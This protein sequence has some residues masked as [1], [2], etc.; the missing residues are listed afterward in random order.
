MQ[1]FEKYRPASLNAV[2]GQDKAVAKVQQ[3]A[4]RAGLAGRAYW[5]SGQSGTGKTTLAKLIAQ[6]V[7]GAWDVDEIDATGLT[8]NQLRELEERLHYKGLGGKGRAVIVNEAHGLNKAVIR[9]LLVILERIPP[10][11]A[12]IFTT[13]IEGQESLFEDYDDASPLLSRCVPLPLARRDLSKAFAERA[14]EIARAE[15][16]DGKPLANYLALAKDCRNNLRLMLSRIEA[17]EMSE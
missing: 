12:W 11:A 15:G 1:L 10:H 16:L 5:I 4:N 3:L 13:T 17:G 6:D 9:S 8:V 14:M 7:A 2:V